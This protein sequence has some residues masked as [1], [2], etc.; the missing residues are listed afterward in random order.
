MAVH[1]LSALAANAAH[2]AARIIV[3][4]VDG[5]RRALDWIAS[6]GGRTVGQWF[7]DGINKRVTVVCKDGHWWAPLVSNL[8]KKHPAWC[9][10]HSG[11]VSRCE[12]IDTAIFT[13]YFG[14]PFRRT[15]AAPMMDGH[16]LDG[17]A[18]VGHALH[19]TRVAFNT[20][21]LQHR[22]RIEKW[23]TDEEFVDQ[24][25][26]DRE[27]RELCAAAGIIYFELHDNVCP[28]VDRRAYIRSLLDKQASSYGW[29]PHPAS[30]DEHTFLANVLKNDDA[31]CHYRELLVE[32]V[33]KHHKDRGYI[34]DTLPNGDPNP[35]SGANVPMGIMCNEHGIRMMR[36]SVVMAGGWCRECYLNSR[37]TPDATLAATLASKYGV[38]FLRAES[39][40][41]A[42]GYTVRKLY[43]HCEPPGA[44]QKHPEYG[45]L[46]VHRDRKLSKPHKSC[47]V[48]M[49][50]SKI[51]EAAAKKVQ[52][53]ESRERALSRRATDSEKVECDHC[54]ATVSRGWLSG[55]LLTN[56]CK[57]G[58]KA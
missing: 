6:K 41:M 40:R 1:G 28:L 56:K 5:E 51:A 4:S 10:K 9:P 35:Y 50:P 38:T 13:E 15:R 53:A 12:R 18:E 22:S 45:F 47:P 52:L 23:Q 43:V 30:D 44:A 11:S 17:Y 29:E 57:L 39:I 25:K 34:P 32:Y 24:L 21:G 54:G 58:K 55:H 49:E 37:R 14:T 48:C 8:A 20:H 26:R 3:A 27:T 36:P 16:E 42:A 46:I 31:A 2:S 33:S 19:T 7:Y